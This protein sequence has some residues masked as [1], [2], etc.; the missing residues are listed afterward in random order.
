MITAWST[1]QTFEQVST[2]DAA[3]TTTAAVVVVVV[4]VVAVALVGSST[5]RNRK[6][7][8]MDTNERGYIY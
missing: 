5:S 8:L 1:F 2:L 4:V 3:T 6:G 7:R